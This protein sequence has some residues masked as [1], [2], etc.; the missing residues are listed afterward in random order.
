[1]KFARIHPIMSEDIAKEG[2]KSCTRP[3]TYSVRVGVA[4]SG[5]L[6]VS[7]TFNRV[8]LNDDDWVP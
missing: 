6:L 7:L 3:N 4:G 8:W 1:M 5:P 2:I